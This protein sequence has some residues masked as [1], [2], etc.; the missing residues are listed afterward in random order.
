MG[1]ACYKIPYPHLCRRQYLEHL[2]QTA[3]PNDTTHTSIDNMTGCGFTCTESPNDTCRSST[4]TRLFKSPAVLLCIPES[5]HSNISITH[6]L[7]LSHTL[8]F[9]CLLSILPSLSRCKCTIN[10]VIKSLSLFLRPSTFS[11]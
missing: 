1:E 11:A 4:L 9:T 5:A 3:H 7:Y 8:S 6:S 2:E 10:P